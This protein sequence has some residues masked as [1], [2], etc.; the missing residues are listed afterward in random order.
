MHPV[1]I[2][3]AL[4]GAALLGGSCGG[5]PPAAS[6]AVPPGASPERP[7]APGALPS[8]APAPAPSAARGTPVDPGP[9]RRAWRRWYTAVLAGDLAEAG[10]ASRD[11]A[12]GWTV[13]TRVVADLDRAAGSPHRFEGSARGEG[14][15]ASS[16]DLIALAATLDLRERAKGLDR[17]LRISSPVL[18][19]YPGGWTLVSFTL[20]D[21][22]LRWSAT[23]LDR[24][25]GGVRV[26]LIAILGTGAETWAITRTTAA[27]GTRTLRAAGGELVT[28][29]GATARLA[30][31]AFSA[32][33]EPVGVWRFPP[34]RD[35]RIVRLRLAEGDREL[36]FR[37]GS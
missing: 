37:F 30:A 34:V 7:P 9:A 13:V 14:V 19:K 24:E 23:N 35:V 16:G 17:R 5:S 10:A 36:E 22:R 20:G 6:P 11:A 31:S 12:N 28:G 1:K 3:L 15:A 21:A 4:A 33:Y 25:S 18:R 27:S 26:R 29:D 8:L 2:A 32:G